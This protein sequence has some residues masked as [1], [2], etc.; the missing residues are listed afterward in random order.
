M[1]SWLRDV[2]NVVQL[3]QKE[4]EELVRAY[5]NVTPVP[6]DA[7]RQ[8]YQ[9]VE[10]ILRKHEGLTASAFRATRRVE[11]RGVAIV[12]ESMVYGNL[13]TLSSGV[14]HV[15]SRDLNTGERQLSGTYNSRSSGRDDGS[16]AV[17][18]VTR[19]LV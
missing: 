9:C 8:L 2:R 10:A 14:G 15:F 5:R 17:R 11:D 7:R 16:A 13:T 1:E 18:A 19:Y 3:S 12:V 4:M 6:E